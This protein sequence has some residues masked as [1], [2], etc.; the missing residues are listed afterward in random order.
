MVAAEI[1][2]GISGLKAAFDLAQGLKNI[3]DAVRRNA[4]VIELSEKILA[5][6]EAQSILLDRVG[7]LEKEVA[8]FETWDA[9][10]E[11]YELKNIGS[12]GVAYMLKP[13]ARGTEPPHWL[14]PNCYAQRKKA[15][16]QPT[17]ASIQRLTVYKCQGCQGNISIGGEPKWLD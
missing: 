16:Y 15:F 10:K 4:A 7:A 8:S 2:S 11:R 6:R 14:C 5:A 3:D 13:N 17:G 12:A 1:I 9:E